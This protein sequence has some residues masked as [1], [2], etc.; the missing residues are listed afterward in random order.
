MV[1]AQQAQDPSRFN[2]DGTFVRGA[3]GFK[4]GSL[5]DSLSISA[6]K[7]NALEMGWQYLNYD[8]IRV[9]QIQFKYKFD[10]QKREFVIIND[11]SQ[12]VRSEMHFEL[13]DGDN[14]YDMDLQDKALGSFVQDPKTQQF[15]LSEKSIENPFI[16][17]FDLNREGKWLGV[18][19]L[20]TIADQVY[21]ELG[22]K[23]KKHNQV[24]QDLML[25][26]VEAQIK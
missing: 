12:Y 18:S 8:K 22:S 17:D 19:S 6:G 2:D 3:S 9:Y 10:A 11:G 13:E 7:G 23:R 5:A 1:R 16:I 20:E 26:Y 24:Q 21:D 4:K 15:I 25:D 14:I